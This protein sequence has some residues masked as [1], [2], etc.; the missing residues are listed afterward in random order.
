[1]GIY[2]CRF[3]NA[4]AGRNI[5][6][7]TDTE[8]ITQTPQKLKDLSQ[9]AYNRPYRTQREPVDGNCITTNM[10][11]ISP[12]SP[13]TPFMCPPC[14]FSLHLLPRPSIRGSSSE[15]CPQA[16]GAT[17]STVHP[18][19]VES[20]WDFHSFASGPCGKTKVQLPGQKAG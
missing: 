10:F 14:G 3:P 16:A 15:A 12:R 2:I 17:L 4:N 19:R 8:N 1:M 5:L 13:Q 18:Q 20:A 11:S 7:A 6:C 9:Y